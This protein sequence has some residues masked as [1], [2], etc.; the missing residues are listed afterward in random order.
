VPVHG[1]DDEVKSKA[2]GEERKRRRVGLG[3]GHGGVRRVARH[4]PRLGTPDQL[5]P[6]T[7]H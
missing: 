5:R 7:L 3:G 1:V 4:A 6:C 2:A